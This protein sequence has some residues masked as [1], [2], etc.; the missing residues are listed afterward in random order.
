VISRW[1]LSGQR[2]LLVASAVAIGM[3]GVAAAP[4]AAQ[5]QAAELS[6][7]LRSGVTAAGLRGHVAR[8]AA[9]ARRNGG[10][11]AVGTAGYRA[12]AAYVHARLRAAGLDVRYQTFRYGGS[13]SRNVI[14]DYSRAGTRRLVTVG[15]HLDSVPAGPG[16]ND[17][18]SG[19]AAV[20]ALAV[21]VA[22]LDP[23]VNVR[24]AFWGAEEVGL[25]G[26][27]SYVG[28]L[29]R[30][31]RA[32]IALY[33]NLDMVG[34]P[35]FVRFVYRAEGRT[36]ARRLRALAARNILVYAL[37]SRRLATAAV[38]LGGRSDHA[39][40]QAAGITTAGLFSG[41]EGVK[42][43]RQARRFGGRAGVSYDPCYHRRCD[44]L[45]NVNFRVAEQLADAAAHA[46]AVVAVDPARLR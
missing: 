37:R 4:A 26:S 38:D 34:S 8:L 24:F 10:N 3:C 23:S 16:A 44:G 15:A 18:G 42:T 5:A 22:R 21:Q 40:F 19:V 28:R 31:E 11:R 13:S 20:L 14:A 17:N 35:N 25:V 43:R 27:R 30:R 41:A 36:R 1:L 7:E 45:A 2:R 39:P 9:I 46:L 12:S 33:L 32:R 6:R 29:S